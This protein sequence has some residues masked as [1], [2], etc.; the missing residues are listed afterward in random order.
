ML[1]SLSLHS[2]RWLGFPGAL[3]KCVSQEGNK[4][5]TKKKT[6]LEVKRYESVTEAV[7]I[8]RYFY[9][10]RDVTVVV[11]LPQSLLLCCSY[12]PTGNNIPASTELFFLPKHSD[13][14]I[15]IRSPKK[16]FLTA[17]EP[18]LRVFAF[19]PPMTCGVPFHWKCVSFIEIIQDWRRFAGLL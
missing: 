17:R 18:L 3:I 15:V 19:S 12:E 9:L 1:L 11:W 10:G 13:H 4:A 2:L 8:Q 14:I 7:N 16:Y 6:C 5:L